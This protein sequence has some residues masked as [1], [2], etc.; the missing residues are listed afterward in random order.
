[1]YHQRKE[2][3]MLEILGVL[4]L[5]YWVCGFFDNPPPEQKNNYLKKKE[6]PSITEDDDVSF[7]KPYRKLFR[8]R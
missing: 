5:F 2:N 7:R 3:P 4:F 6:S 8:K 1:M